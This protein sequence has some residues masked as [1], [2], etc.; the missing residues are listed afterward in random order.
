MISYRLNNGKT[1]NITDPR[2]LRTFYT[3]LHYPAWRQA[4][5]PYELSGWRFILICSSPA[6]LAN[7]MLKAFN[8]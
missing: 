8:W 5:P 4:R 7:W 2:I 3:R 1:G 6:W